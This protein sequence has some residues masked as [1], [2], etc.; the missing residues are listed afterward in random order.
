MTRDEQIA[1]AAAA[2]DVIDAA[3]RIIA[4]PARN[5]PSAST[6]T[7]YSLAVATERCWEVCLETE[8]LVRALAMP[9]ETFTA[10]EQFL[11]RDRAVQTQADRIVRL[12][13]ALRGESPK[14]TDNG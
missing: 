7:V 3:G 4:G 11:R 6:A 10:E 2:V 9:V 12:M 5:A 8:L 13:A 14:E 1:A